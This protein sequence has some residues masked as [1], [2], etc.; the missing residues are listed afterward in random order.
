MNVGINIY[1]SLLISPYKSINSILFIKQKV[2]MTTCSKNY[3]CFLTLRV[4]VVVK[5]LLPA[6]N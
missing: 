2:K 3:T 4:I 5:N 6:D 1:E